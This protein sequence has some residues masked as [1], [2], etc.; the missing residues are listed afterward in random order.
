MR[1]AIARFMAIIC[2]AITR[3]VEGVEEQ[4]DALVFGPHCG[5]RLVERVLR[6]LNSAVDKDI[7]ELVPAL[8]TWHSR[9]PSFSW[10]SGCSGL[11]TPF[12][13]FN[14]IADGLTRL[15]VPDSFIELATRASTQ[16][17]TECWCRTSDRSQAY[18]W[19]ESPSPGHSE[20]N[21]GDCEGVL[22]TEM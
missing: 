6:N 4:P 22:V 19:S 15:G 11:D 14:A 16:H 1:V 5:G 17:M 10:V 2:V 9:Y 12:F 21:I 13:A 3:T 20:S 8:R 7:R 18:P